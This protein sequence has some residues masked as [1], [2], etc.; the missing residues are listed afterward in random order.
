[1]QKLSRIFYYAKQ[2]CRA[3]D[4]ALPNWFPLF[5]WIGDIF[6]EVWLETGPYLPEKRWE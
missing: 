3:V 5:S 2:L 1:M 6:E 4:D